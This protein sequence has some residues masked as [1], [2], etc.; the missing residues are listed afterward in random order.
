MKDRYE[1]EA[2]RAVAAAF[3]I[4]LVLT[5]LLFVWVASPA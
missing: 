1:E 5:A 4:S 3:L 2:A